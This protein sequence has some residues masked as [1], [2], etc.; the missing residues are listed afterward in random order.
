M[1]R[2]VAEHERLRVYQLPTTLRDRNP[3]ENG[4]SDDITNSASVRKRACGK[5]SAGRL[6]R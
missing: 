4:W 6:F 2:F 3:V 1:H 5:G